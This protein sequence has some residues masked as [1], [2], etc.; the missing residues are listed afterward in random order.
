[1]FEKCKRCKYRREIQSVRKYNFC[2]L[3]GK[4]FS[5]NEPD[6]FFCCENHQHRLEAQP[7]RRSRWSGCGRGVINAS[8]IATHAFKMKLPD[9]GSAK[10]GTA[11]SQCIDT[12]HPAA[13][14]SPRRRGRN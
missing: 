5:G 6:S 14:P 7:G 12:A 8:R 1:M 13:A 4:S 3:I 9:A 2:K 11:I 10:M